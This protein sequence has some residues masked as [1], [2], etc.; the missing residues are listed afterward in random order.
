MQSL[1]SAIGSHQVLVTSNSMKA[2]YYIGDYDYEF[3]PSVVPETRSGVE[4]GT[5]YRTGRPVIGTVESLARVTQG[6]E[7]VLVLVERKKI[8]SALLRT[9]GVVDWLDENCS[10]LQTVATGPLRAW[11]VISVRRSGAARSGP[12]FLA[13]A[14][15]RYAV[16]AAWIGAAKALER[17]VR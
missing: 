4:F 8:A 1:A 6:G 7:R 10:E 9:T 13:L 17:H 14:E 12:S 2:L 15:V 3:N 11:T 16:D 5:D